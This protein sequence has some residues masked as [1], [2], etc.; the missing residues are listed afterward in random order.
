MSA[1][2]LIDFFKGKPAGKSQGDDPVAQRHIPDLFLVKGHA[3]FQ[4]IIL[5][6]EGS[7]AADQI[8]KDFLHILCHVVP[9]FLLV[10]PRF[11]CA[12]VLLCIQ[13]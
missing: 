3:G 13:F 10:L 9:A 2:S 5:F 11:F 8:L 7:H 12:S 6:V 1:Q 4:E